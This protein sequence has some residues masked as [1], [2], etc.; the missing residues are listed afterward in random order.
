[1]AMNQ[2][3]FQPGLSMSEFLER[4]GTEENCEAA[5]FASRWPSGWSCPSCGCTCSSSFVRRGRRYWQCSRHRHQSTLISGTAFEA[6]KLP[7]TRWFLAMHL[8]TQAKNN[9]SALELMRHLGVCYQSALLMKHKVMEVMRLREEGRRLT[10]RVEID[11]AYLGGERSGGK[12]GRGTE[13][14]VSF[15]AAVQTT[16]SGQAVLACFA[17]LPFTKE[18]V[19]DFM[20]RSLALPLTVVSDGLGCFTA[21]QGRGA[22]HDREVTGGGKASVKLE[23]FRAVNTVLGNLKTPITGTY[24][25]FNFAKY[26]H[27]YLA[28]VQYRFNRRFDLSSILVRLLRAAVLTKPLPGRSLRAA[29]LCR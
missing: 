26:A 22:V 1:M 17:A 4:Y 27:R 16:E 14:K 25:A 3:Q 19:S 13:N 12:R 28:E 8:L 29:E 18:A 9:L 10:G 7:L 20:D 21:A 23:K 6:T 2:V 24:H 5:L 11:D 15:V